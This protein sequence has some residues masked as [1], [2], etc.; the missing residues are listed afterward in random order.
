MSALPT[1][2]TSGRTPAAP[3]AKN[4]PVRPNPVAI[5]S[6]TSTSA[7]SSAT[8]RITRR[9]SA[10]YTNI[11]PAPCSSGSTM[12]PASSRACSAASARK[13]AAQPSTSPPGAGGW[14]AKTCR[15][16]T[17][18]NIECIPP[19]GSQTLMQPKVSPW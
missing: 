15:G 10:S 18:L 19:T 12:I 6:K 8:S 11:P 4:V 17:S 16:S 2:I 9:H 14:S 3:A 5:S 1:H 13:P 7:C